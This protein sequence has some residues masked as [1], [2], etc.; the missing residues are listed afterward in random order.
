MGKM[1]LNGKEYSGSGS[2][3]HE[4]STDEKIVGKWVDGKP[5]YEKTVEIGYLSNN[6]STPYPHGI[7]NI[8]RVVSHSGGAI[9]SSGVYLPLPKV[10]PSG[11]QYAVDIAVTTSDIVISTG[12]DR[13]GYYGYVTLRY[14]KTTD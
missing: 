1:I 3:W 14:T 10:S 13:S 12:S 5:L 4:Y 6:T 7:S 2:E 11:L 9:N 8:K